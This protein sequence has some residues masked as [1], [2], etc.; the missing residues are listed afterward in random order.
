[1]FPKNYSLFD[2][3]FTD[4]F[5]HSPNKIMKADIE[6]KENQYRITIDLPGFSKEEIK[7]SLEKGYL[8]IIASKKEQKEE[9][10]KNHYVKQE[11]Y[12]GECSRSFFIG[13]NVKEEEI[14]ASLEQG[15]LQITIPKKAQE[16]LSTRNYIPID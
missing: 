2:D 8:M 1:M 3:F 9:K 15:L 7:I 6:E 14:K 11:R 4:S 13:E 16:K 5:F 12:Y 10:E